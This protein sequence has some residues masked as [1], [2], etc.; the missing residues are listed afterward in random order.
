MSKSSTTPAS[1]FSDPVYLRSELREWGK[2]I[3]QLVGRVVDMQKEIN[4]LRSMIQEQ[5]TPLRCKNRPRG[6]TAV[7]IPFSS[8]KKQR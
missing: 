5:S 2:L 1:P 6:T 8:T 4:L 7:V 3:P